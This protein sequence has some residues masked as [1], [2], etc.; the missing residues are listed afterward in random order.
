MAPSLMS[1]RALA[2]WG[3]AALVEGDEPMVSPEGAEVPVEQGALIWVKATA[4]TEN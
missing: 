2:W 3:F 4:M 1:C